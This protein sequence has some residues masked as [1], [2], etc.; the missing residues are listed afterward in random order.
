MAIKKSK[1]VTRT[2]KLLSTLCDKTFLKLW[3]Y[4]NPF[5]DDRKELCD[6]IAVFEDHVFIFFDRE[7]LK[8]DGVVKDILVTWNRWKRKAIDKQINPALPRC[9]FDLTTAHPDFGIR[10]ITL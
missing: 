6:L 9:P 1:G 2:E 7:S 8:F 5:N 3:S 10:I 4:P